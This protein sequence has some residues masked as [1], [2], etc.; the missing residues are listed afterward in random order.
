MTEK[1]KEIKKTREDERKRAK[2]EKF[3][4]VYKAKGDFGHP[5]KD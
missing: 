5:P 1:S 4:M 2:Y 3:K